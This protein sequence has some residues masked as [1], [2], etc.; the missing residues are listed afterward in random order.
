MEDL[1]QIEK[2]KTIS[3]FNE[4]DKEKRTMLVT[5]ISFFNKVGIEMKKLS[6]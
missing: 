4:L 5:S 1:T 6:S 2:G 3:L